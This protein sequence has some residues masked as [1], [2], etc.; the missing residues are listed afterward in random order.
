MSLLSLIAQYDDFSSPLT[1]IHNKTILNLLI[2][3]N[4]HIDPKIYSSF[5]NCAVVGSSG[6]LLSRHLGS[7]IDGYDAIFRSNEAVTKTFEKYVGKR[8]TVRISA[9]YMKKRSDKL[10]ES[11]SVIRLVRCFRYAP[12]YKS[13]LSDVGIHSPRLKPDIN[14]RIYEEI[15]K[16]TKMNPAQKSL[17][18]GVVTVYRSVS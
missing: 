18:T 12:C 1:S 9:A 2:N 17:S 6:A 15:S 4:Q 3:Y 16:L 14:D 13:L 10:K 8:T 11:S 5:E 7:V